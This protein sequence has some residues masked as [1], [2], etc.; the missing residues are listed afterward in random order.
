MQK[1]FLFVALNL[2]C[3]AVVLP[4]QQDDV[5]R[6]RGPFTHADSLRGG[7]HPAR[8]GYDAQFYDLHLNIN[9]ADSSLRGY[10]VL[11]LKALTS[12]DS[13]QVDLFRHWRISRITLGDDT[14]RYRREG[15]AIFVKFKQTVAAGQ[16][17]QLA[18]YYRPGTAALCGEKTAKGGPGW[19]WPARVLGPA[20]GGHSKTTWPTSPIACA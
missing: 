4:A 20:V 19:A 7:Q 1:L 17:F 11:H 10:N 3:G 13:I 15:H 5:L 16:A 6:G 9:P 2:L 18:V 8:A 12:L 14:L